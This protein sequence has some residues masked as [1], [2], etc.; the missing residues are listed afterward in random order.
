M[1]ASRWVGAHG[2]VHAF[3]PSGR[4][5]SRLVDHVTLNALHN[6][7]A[8]RQAI[9]DRNGVAQLRVAPFPNAG[10]NTLGAS[11][12]YPQVQTERIETVDMVTLDAFVRAQAITHVDAIKMDIEGSEHAALSGA[13]DVL[14]RFRPALIVEFSRAALERCGSTPERLREL[15]TASRYTLHGIDPEGVPASPILA[16]DPLPDGDLLALPVDRPL[17]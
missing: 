1:V 11:F 5:Y 17:I 2:H 3:E 9:G 6:V 12:A 4:E 13:V 7:D 16:G 15:L 14:G 8:R 10:H